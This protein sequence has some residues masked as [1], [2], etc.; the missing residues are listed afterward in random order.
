M[1]P[2]YGEKAGGRLPAFF[3]GASDS[4]KGNALRLV[5]EALRT[6]SVPLRYGDAPD[7]SGNRRLRDAEKVGQIG[8]RMLTDNEFK[9]FHLSVEN[10]VFH[11]S[12]SMA[13]LWV[14]PTIDSQ[15]NYNSRS[16]S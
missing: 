6:E 12:L 7:G 14:R 2:V 16:V 15:K 10:L 13:V 3:V 11:S 5:A 1:C 8:S 4:I 9:P